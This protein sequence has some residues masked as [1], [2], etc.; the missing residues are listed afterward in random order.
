[1]GLPPGKFAPLQFSTDGI[2]GPTAVA[3]WRELCGRELMK[4]TMEP[5]GDGPFHCSANVRSL[6]GLTI[7]SIT[8]SPNRLVRTPALAADGNDDFFVVIPTQGSTIISATGREVTLGPGDATMIAGDSANLSIIPTLSSFLTLSIPSAMLAS[9]IV[10]L[11]SVLVGVIPAATDALQLLVRYLAALG[12]DISLAAPGTRQQFVTHIVDL[13]VLAAGAGR[14]VTMLAQGRG[15][16]AARLHAIKAD[17][18]RNIA[19][20]NLSAESLAAQ[21]RVSSRYVRRLFE[22]EGL[23]FT[24][25]VLAER[26]HRAHAMLRDPRE[27]RPINVIAFDAGF[28]DLSYFN[29]T[30]RR[31]Y[32]ATPSAIRHEG[33]Q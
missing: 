12:D 2:Q 16:R 6:P 23:T 13:V 22:S 4:V 19:Q 30:F 29:K 3:A 20:A 9:S 21:H 32:G 31:R 8:S 28:N 5:L 26:L 27:A 33:R 14:D 7:A 10:S 11:D 18:Q 24:E 25:F 17:I 15:R 1:M